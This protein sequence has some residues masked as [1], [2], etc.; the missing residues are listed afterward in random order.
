MF[1]ETPVE[2]YELTKALS[3]QGKSISAD[4]VNDENISETL[5]EIE[6]LQ[7]EAVISAVDE[8][9]EALGLPKRFM[10]VE[11]T[12]DYENDNYEK[13]ISAGINDKTIRRL[14]QRG[15]SMAEIADA[16][17]DYDGNPLHF[18]G[19]LKSGREA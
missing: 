18:L 1:E 7:S 5:E 9:L 12:R 11:K 6:K 2:A 4:S 17:E 13:A 14:K 3:K 19:L 16:S 15:F 10:N 8:E